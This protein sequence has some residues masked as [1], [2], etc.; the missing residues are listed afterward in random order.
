MTDNR[1]EALREALESLRG[2]TKCRCI[3]DF[4]DRDMQDPECHCDYAEDVETIAAALLTQP[5]DAGASVPA[6]VAAAIR[7]HIAATEHYAVTIDAAE[8]KSW[9]WRLEAMG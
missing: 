7:E 4:K 9:A 2:L 6:S 5:A 8:L 3:P 1:D